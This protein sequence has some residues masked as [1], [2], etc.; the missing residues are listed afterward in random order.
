MESAN[1]KNLSS[2]N[3]NHRHVPLYI[4]LN[5]WHGKLQNHRIQKFHW[6][7]GQSSLFLKQSNSC[8]HW[9]YL[10]NKHSLSKI[11]TWN[12]RDKSQISYHTSFFVEFSFFQ[13]QFPAIKVIEIL[14][15]WI[16]VQR[17]NFAVFRN[18]WHFCV[19][20]QKKLYFRSTLVDKRPGMYFKYEFSWK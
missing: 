8:R 6:F 18:T 10:K 2:Q 16:L 17:W 15:C 14:T 11:F 19:Y 7:P 13:I 4:F 5:Q 1:P 20:F 3:Y 12:H 9:L